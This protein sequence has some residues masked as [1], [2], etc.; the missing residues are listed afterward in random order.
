MNT[1]IKNYLGVAGIITILLLGYSAWSY[2]DSYAR[3]IQPS[4]FRSFVVTGEGKVVAVPDVAE[5]T[6][7]VVT[8]G[9]KNIADSE[10]KNTEAANAAIEYVKDKGVDAKDVKTQGYNITP[11]YQYYSCPTGPLSSATPCPPSEIVGYT[12]SQAVLVK[13]RDFSKVGDI[14][15]GVVAAGANQTSGLNFTIDDPT[16]VKNQARTLAIQKA[17]AQAKIV[18][19]AGGFSVGRLLGLDENNYYPQPI[20]YSKAMGMG[21]DAS[22][23][24]PAPSIEPGSQEVTVNVT[25]RYEIK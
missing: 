10:K 13:V 6:F 5:F 11:R 7:S 23:S 16:A 24:M 21:G 19:R 1:R 18:A 15:S 12:I 17:Q 3:S 20:Y 25:L 14:L 9:G 4:S 8:E 22:E 2:V